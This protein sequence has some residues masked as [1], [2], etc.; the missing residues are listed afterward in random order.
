MEMGEEKEG[1]TGFDGGTPSL[2]SSMLMMVALRGTDAMTTLHFFG[3]G[4]GFL[5]S[6]LFRFP[7]DGHFPGRM[8]IYNTYK[9]EN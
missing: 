4:V 1:G 8:C 6:S 7:F 3:L 5:L 2:S 9:S